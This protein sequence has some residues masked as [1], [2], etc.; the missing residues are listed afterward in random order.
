MATW[1]QMATSDSVAALDRATAELEGAFPH[2]LEAGHAGCMHCDDPTQEEKV[3]RER[4]CRAIRSHKKQRAD[5]PI[6]MLS[7]IHFGHGPAIINGSFRRFAYFVPALLVDYLS[8]DTEAGP[9]KHGAPQHLAALFQEAVDSGRI[10]GEDAGGRWTDAERDALSLFFAAA[11]SAYTSGPVGDPFT[12]VSLC[13]VAATMR[14]IPERLAAVWASDVAERHLLA[15][16]GM[17]ISTWQR[18]PR[19]LAIVAHD[20]VLQSLEG[21]FDCESNDE[22]RG[23]SL[24]KAEETLRWLRSVA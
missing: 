24:S 19:A 16:A 15:A 2:K 9:G 12:A 17:D 10:Y 20:T 11:L 5:L 21:R 4:F 3:E 6:R 23:K 1:L 14:A 8:A 7:R 13:E 22:E 18:Y